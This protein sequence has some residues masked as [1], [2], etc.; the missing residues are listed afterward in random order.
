MEAL[1]KKRDKALSVTLLTQNNERNGSM[2]VLP[3]RITYKNKL[4]QQ[5]SNDGQQLQSDRSNN[6]NS[7]CGDDAAV[8][9]DSVAIATTSG[10]NAKGGFQ[11]V[12]Y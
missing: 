6:D 7:V 1:S 2:F 8:K 9:D 5:K 10:G 4:L 3:L 12:G 11:T